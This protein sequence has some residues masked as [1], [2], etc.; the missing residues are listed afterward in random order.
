[1]LRSISERSEPNDC[2]I[3]FRVTGMMDA[4]RTKARKHGHRLLHPRKIATLD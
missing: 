3:L 2:D 4:A 1:M